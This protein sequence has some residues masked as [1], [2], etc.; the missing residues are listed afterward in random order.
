V[1]RLPI[2]ELA[3]LDGGAALDDEAGAGA[4][5]V[6]RDAKKRAVVGAYVCETWGEEELP[7]AWYAV[8]AWSAPNVWLVLC[9]SV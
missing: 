9:P 5:Y 1:T 2:L 4:V 3:E 6:D 7:E 8:Y